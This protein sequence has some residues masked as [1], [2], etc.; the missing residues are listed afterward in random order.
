MTAASMI[1][2]ARWLCGAL[3]LALCGNA[4]AQTV[5]AVT[6]TD[7]GR[8][9]SATTGD[10]VFTI[11]TNGTVSRD[12]GTGVRVTQGA[13]S[14]AQVSINCAVRAC[15]NTTVRIRIAALSGSNRARALT[16]FT[17]AG[18]TLSLGTP[19]GVGTNVILVNATNRIRRGDTLTFNVGMTIPIAGEDSG[20][21]TGSGTS[22][23]QVQVCQPAPS[24]TPTGNM[25]GSVTVSVLR[26]ILLTVNSNMSFGAVRRPTSGSGTV[27][28]NPDNTRSVTG[29]GAFFWDSPPWGAAAFTV[30]GEGGQVI[31]VGIPSTFVMTKAGAAD[32]ITVT[33]SNN[34]VSSVL[35]GTVGG[36][37]TLP[38]RVGGTF[39][40]SSTTA[41]GNYSGSL[42]VTVQYN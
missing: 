2:T 3:L 38:F 37:G 20:L 27:T 12:S 7:L 6:A 14:S 35:G 11:A 10:T 5:S 18:G 31:S 34:I 42:L 8:V 30:S 26:P 17:V 33:T 28:L 13:V 40:F 4:A 23:F 15:N 16:T 39:P 1:R 9:V 41:L 21:N 29:T 36:A 19:T 24:C 32:T 22:G 25:T